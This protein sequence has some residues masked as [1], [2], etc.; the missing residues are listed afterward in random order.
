[1]ARA[2][3]IGG[4]PRV[5]KSTLAAQVL[6]EHPGNIISTD[7]LRAS[8]RRTIPVHAQPDLYYL[9]SLNANEREMDR[10]MREQT[11]DIIEAA[12]RESAVV[13]PAVEAFVREHLAT[14][15]DVLV[16]GVAVLP[17]FIADLNFD[18]SVVFLGNQSP[19]HAQVIHDYAR[20]HRKTWLGQ[21][22]PSTL[23]AFAIFSAA[24]SAHIE[25]EARKYYLPYV[26]MG[27]R[28]FQQGIEQARKLLLY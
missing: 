6:T 12:D 17:E 15:R 10:L 11:I 3:F 9:D 1:M 16:E 22:A 7:D 28:G 2:L 4:A 27:N 18:Y 23:D 25:R 13:W 20:T 21:L 14:G 26:E 19:D 5:G 8:L 24:T